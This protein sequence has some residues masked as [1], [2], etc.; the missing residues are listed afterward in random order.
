MIATV[1]RIGYSI[2]F[3]HKKESLFNLPT[4]SRAPP[5]E[6]PEGGTVEAP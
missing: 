1:M 3:Y 5:R 4:S 6:T 2:F